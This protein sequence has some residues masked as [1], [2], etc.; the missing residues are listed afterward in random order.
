M[1]DGAMLGRSRRAAATALRQRV[2]RREDME[3]A[4]AGWGQCLSARPWARGHHDRA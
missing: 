3:N 4:E 2:A 1:L